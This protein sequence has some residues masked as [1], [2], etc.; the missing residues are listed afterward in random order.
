MSAAP[1]ESAAPEERAVDIDI[2]GFAPAGDGVGHF[3]GAAV[4]V[5]GTI[6]GERARVAIDQG[7]VRGPVQGRLLDLLSRSP[8]RLPPVCPHA[9]ICGGCQWLHVAPKRQREAKAAM[10]AQALGQLLDGIDARPMAHAGQDL[11]YRARATLH[12]SGGRLGF[13]QKRSH[14][15]VTVSACP[16]LDA[17]INAALTSLQN[18]LGEASDSWRLPRGTVDVA[19]A[20][21]ESRVSAAFFLERLSDD[22]QSR[23]SRLVRHAALDGALAVVN[24]RVTPLVGKPVL[25]R[26]APSSTRAFLRTRP[27]LFAQAHT[28]ANALLVAEVVD[29]LEGAERVLEL[30]GG[31]GNFTLALAERV[32]ALVSIEM[33]AGALELARQSAREASFSHVRFIVGDAI[34]QARD[35]A[36]SGIRFDALLLDPP[37]GGAPGIAEVAQALDVNRVVYV[38]C[39]PATLARDAHSLVATGYRPTFARAF[40][41]FPQTVH[42]E[43]VMVFE[44]AQRCP[45]SRPLAPVRPA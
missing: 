24:G 9:G 43:G 32:K 25:Q 39:N 15:V 28:M 26:R 18:L 19:L 1:L 16:L 33:C 44:R 20:C 35:L 2:E 34:R 41:M 31:S 6:G 37:R 12:V 23:L 7:D 8:D 13:S 40:D 14:A 38:S 11:G 29:R 21:D 22:A 45:P 10:F 27:D 3:Q 42:L 17:R 30:Y 4:F 36:R 5:P